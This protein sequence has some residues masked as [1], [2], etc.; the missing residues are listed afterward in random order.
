M[1][2]GPKLLN[3]LEN[4][5]LRGKIML[6][7]TLA[8]NGL[9]VYGKTSGDWAVHGLGNELSLLF[10]TPHGASLSIAYPAWLELHK[11]KI[12]DRIIKLGNGLFGV[13]TVDET[14]T[15]LKEFFSLIGS[16]VNLKEANIMECDIDK[17]KQQYITNK[18]SGMHHKLDE[19]DYE[20][21]LGFMNR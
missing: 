1:H 10:D 7:A 18:V 14:I 19:N 16:P 15:K 2:W 8:L 3:D 6:D 4:V 20:T 21:L 11:N 13:N 5:D 12:P 9:T 17:I